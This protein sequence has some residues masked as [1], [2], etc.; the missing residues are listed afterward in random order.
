[1][2]NQEFVNDTTRF[3]DQ[4]PTTVQ[5]ALTGPANVTVNF[6]VKYIAEKRIQLSWTTIGFTST[7]T[8]TLGTTTFPVSLRPV[9]TQIS[10]LLWLQEGG[11]FGMGALVIFPS[12]VLDFQSFPI[13]AASNHIFGGFLTTVVFQI[14]P[15]TIEYDIA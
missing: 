13:L 8:V 10:K 12:G 15:D 4:R 14:P 2:N 11:V 3:F 5:V 9:V 7:S 1:M 6:K